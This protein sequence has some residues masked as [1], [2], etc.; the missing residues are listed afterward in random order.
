MSEAE[1]LG[2]LDELE[3]LVS[4]KLQ[5][6]SYK[7]LSLTFLLSSDTSKRLLQEFVQSHEDGLQVVYSLTGCLKN[8]PSIYHV[9]LVPGPELEDA[10][11]DF[12]G[13]CSVQV[14]S[15]Q[16]CMP[17]DPAT[18]WNSESV[19]A[20]ELF[21]QPSSVENCLRDNRFCGISNSFVRRNAEGTSF[22]I[23][24]PQVN[25]LRAS[26]SSIKSTHKN[27]TAPPP[28]LKKLQQTNQKDVQH[29]SNVAEDVKSEADASADLNQFGKPTADKGNTTSLPA[30]KKVGQNNKATAVAGGSL[31]NL[32]GRAST[33]SKD[34]KPVG[35]SAGTTA[36]DSTASAEPQLCAREAAQLSSDDE[37][38]VNFRRASH[39][40]A[41]R[42]RRVVFEFSDEENEYEDV[43]NLASPDIPKA[44][45]FLASG[46][47]QRNDKKPKLDFDEGKDQPK[48]KKENSI[49]N[50]LHQEE[51]SAHD[52]GRKTAISTVEKMQSSESNS[53]GKRTDAAPTSPKRKKVLKTRIDE[54]GREVT[55]VVWEGKETEKSKA[56]SFAM[57]KEN[58]ETKTDAGNR[59]PAAKKP[60]SAVPSNATGKA[61]NKKAGSKDPKQGNIL[62]FFK[63]V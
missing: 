52:A 54:R 56:D 23:T 15:V 40:E 19:Q 44:Q 26:G 21:G 3:A 62:S 28:Q 10:K 60:P 46:E 34:S 12:D 51:I 55:E 53:N 30:D 48:V 18:I 37:A 31:A 38:E 7:W 6:V 63:R 1:T 13:S 42:K 43:V 11:Q 16:A 59:P 35:G 33:K 49:A 32:W 36:P 20:K 22:D 9:R 8:N 5:V 25:G 47:D 4:D 58:N 39:G 45:S 41:G 17:K 14:Y 50:E 2:I 61:G 27:E 24:G 57:K 29:S